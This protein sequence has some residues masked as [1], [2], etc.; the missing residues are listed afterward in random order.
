MENKKNGIY[1]TPPALA[2]YLVKPFENIM[3]E[4][5]LDPSYGEGSLLLAAGRILK[6]IY[7]IY[8]THLFGCDTQPVNG[9]LRHLPKANLREIDFF[10]FPS[11]N[12]F[13]TILMNPPYIRH[14][15]QDL[16]KIYKY[17]INYPQL[18]IL[19]KKAD[20]WAFFLVKAVSHLYVGGNIGAILP[21]AFLQADY[22][23]P[24]RKWLSEIF[25]EI[26]VVALNSKYFEKADERVVILWLKGYGS[27]CISIKTASSKS[28][29]STIIFTK[30][31]FQ[32]WISDRVSYF[33]VNNIDKVLKRCKSEFGFTELSDHA[34][35]KIGIVTGAV[36]YFIM[37]KQKAMEI[38][39][40]R[41]QL[42]PILTRPNEFT[43]YI[44][45]GK[46]ELK[47]LISLNVNDHLN[48]KNYI[49]RGIENNIHLRA[50]SVLREH[51]YIVKLN[52]VPDAFFQ[53]RI[54]KTPFLLP[55]HD[56][57]QSTNSIHRVYFRDVTEIEKKWIIVS[58][59]S[60]PSQLSV[61]TNSKTYGRGILKIE[62]K[63]L[64]NTLVIRRNDPIIISIYE[65]II[66]LL[67]VDKK[68]DAMELASEF[69][70]KEIGIPEDLM[71]LAKEEL[72]K[73]QALR[74]TKDT[75]LI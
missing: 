62:P 51:W 10:D 14:S 16:S 53:Y 60:I 38:G 11:D 21:W 9:L 46:K 73:F 27:K 24:L 63:S 52:E 70:S 56:K 28:I 35:V 66:A 65:K 39:F 58:I 43:N 29:E 71:R 8:E 34:E 4:K 48:H 2:D 17:R 12:M 61:E 31:S 26:N 50:H 44:K 18:K 45:T 33:G 75:I 30:L 54:K 32:N 20:L 41:N 13:Q 1:Y 69:I 47:F 22:A 3:G 64:K 25:L 67:S 55:N 7:R 72:S 36:D 15:I 74:L 37:T 42:V 6:N 57:V 23:K 49:E 40:K 68:E 19:N 59:L 5:I